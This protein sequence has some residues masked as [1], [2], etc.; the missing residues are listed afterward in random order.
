MHFRCDFYPINIGFT[1]SLQVDV[2]SLLHLCNSLTDESQVT[3]KLS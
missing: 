1:L 3:N 2:L